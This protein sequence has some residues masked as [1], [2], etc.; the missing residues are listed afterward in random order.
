[1]EFQKSKFDGSVDQ[2]TQ[3]NLC[4]GRRLARVPKIA[5]AD[6]P[7]FPTIELLFHRH[8]SFF[9]E[10]CLV[11]PV[12]RVEINVICLQS[13]QTRIDCADTVCDPG[14]P[15][16]YFLPQENVENFTNRIAYDVLGPLKTP[17]YRPSIRPGTEA[18]D[19]SVPTKR[20]VPHASCLRWTIRCAGKTIVLPLAK[21]LVDTSERTCAPSDVRRQQKVRLVDIASTS[22]S[23]GWCPIGL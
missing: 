20:W 13:L 2:A 6:E 12:R 22:A 8:N 4:F 11:G 5:H 1:M 21:G 10:N 15:R 23:S 19:R 17:Q 16:R 9:D 7:D 3:A 14:M 18:Y